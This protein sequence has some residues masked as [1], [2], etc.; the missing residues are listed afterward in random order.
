MAKKIT[1]EELK[2]L[3]QNA[4]EE[5]LNTAE[6]AD[7]FNAKYGSENAKLTASDITRFKELV[8]LKGA[9]P[10]KKRNSVFEIVEEDEIEDTL[11]FEEDDSPVETSEYEP[12]EE[13]AQF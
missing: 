2:D 5:G 12:A 13:I 9:K 3:I 6:I 7:K 8:G 1:K 11:P 10:K 4:L